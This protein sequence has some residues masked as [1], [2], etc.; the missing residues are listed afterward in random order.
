MHFGVPS[1]IRTHDVPDTGWNTQINVWAMGDLYGE[2][3]PFCLWGRIFENPKV[4]NNITV[5]SI[6]GKV[7]ELFFLL[8]I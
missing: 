2:L 1:G 3:G 7:I 6:L 4:Y 5:F 8:F